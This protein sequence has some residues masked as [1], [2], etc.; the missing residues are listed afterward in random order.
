MRQL[1]RKFGPQ[2]LQ[3]L[4]R[5][6]RVLVCQAATEQGR[7]SCGGGGCAVHG[8]AFRND[9]RERP[10]ALF[11]R[12][13]AEKVGSLPPVF[14]VSIPLLFE[15]RSR[16]RIV[17]SAACA[18]TRVKTVVQEELKSEKITLFTASDPAAS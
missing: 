17:F 7:R 3:D 2:P 13:K 10:H 1:G 14:V 15:F 11:G 16:H 18:L 8:L 5:L 12:L 9:G 6:I 4:F